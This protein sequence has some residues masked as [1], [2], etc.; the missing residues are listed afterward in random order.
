VAD[1]VR[2]M[3]IR[4]V[5]DG[6]E[7]DKDVANGIRYAVDNGA[8]VINMSFG[9]PY[10][11][12]KSAVDEAIR[13]AESRGVLLVHAAGNNG[14]DIDATDNFPTR[15]YT[16]GVQASN[17]LE[18]GASTFTDALAAEFSNYGATRVDLFAPGA[19]ITTLAPDGE[20][21]TTDG[22]SLAAPVVSGVAAL[23]LS[24]YPALTP[25]QVRQLLLDSARRLPETEVPRPGSDERVAF[26]ALSSTGGLLDAAAAVAAAA[27]MA[28]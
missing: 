12:G 10:S 25:L 17:W 18:I 26:G 14:A 22:T 15:V 5:P 21:Q 19:R 1:S 27:A 2:I 23:I 7:R 6:D 13:Y 24:H 4:V 20:V 11:P 8:Q 3:A 9:K 28:Q 16:D